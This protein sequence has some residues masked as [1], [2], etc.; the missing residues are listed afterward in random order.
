ME[1]EEALGLMK[2][3]APP[4]SIFVNRQ[5]INQQSWTPGFLGTVLPPTYYKHAVIVS[6]GNGEQQI[7]VRI[8]IGSAQYNIRGDRFDVVT[9]ANSTVQILI[10]NYDSNT[11]RTTPLIEILSLD[12]S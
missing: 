11:P 3:R 12:W 9:I 4:P 5:V 1:Q 2:V 6:H 7:E 10:A 8:Y